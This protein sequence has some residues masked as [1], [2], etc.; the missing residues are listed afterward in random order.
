V[1]VLDLLNVIVPK[2]NDVEAKQL[3][4]KA[5]IV[6]ETLSVGDWMTIEIDD[7]SKIT[8]VNGEWKEGWREF[9]AVSF[10]EAVEMLSTL[11]EI[12]EELEKIKI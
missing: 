8:D 12:E 6:A 5:K 3:A 1:R 9:F 11:W 7:V 4:K 2:V 10:D